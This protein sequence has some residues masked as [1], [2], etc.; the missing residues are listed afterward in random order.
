MRVIVFT[1]KNGKVFVTEGGSITMQLCHGNLEMTR[2]VGLIPTEEFFEAIKDGRRA[3]AKDGKLQLM[4][5]HGMLSLTLPDMRY[6]DIIV[7][8]EVVNLVEAESPF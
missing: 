2:F 8:Q 5:A 3:V 7:N 1:T 4:V 6:S